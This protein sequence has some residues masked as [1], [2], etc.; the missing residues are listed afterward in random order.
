MWGTATGRHAGRQEVGMCRTRGESQGTY[1][2]YATPRANKAAH[3][4]FEIQRIS[5]Q[6]SETG[7]SV[8]R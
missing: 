5:H 7:V 6:K 8:A 4:G 3:S 2:T 1:I